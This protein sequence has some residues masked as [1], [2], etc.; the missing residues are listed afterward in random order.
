MFAYVGAVGRVGRPGLSGS[1]ALAK[2]PSLSLD[3]M[4][5]GTLDPRITF[6]RAST[7][8]YTDASG[9]IQTAAVNAPR[10]DYDPVTHALRGV[11]IEEQRTNVMF[12]SVPGVGW[13][14]SAVTLVPNS[15]TAPD[16]TNTFVKSANTATT[17]FHSTQ[18]AQAG[19]AN[20][21]YTC[22]AYIKRGEFRYVQFIFDDLGGGTPATIAT[23]DLQTATVSGGIGIITNVG[24][25]VYRCSITSIPTGASTTGIRL[26]INNNTIPNGGF[27]D[28]SYLGVAGE[29]TYIWGAQVEQGAF[30]TSYIPT[31]SVAVTR[32]ADVATMPTNVSWFSSSAGSL[33]AEFAL[34]NQASAGTQG[35]IAQLDDGTPNNS[36]GLITVTGPPVFHTGSVGGIGIISA[37][38][39][40]AITGNPQRAVSSYGGGVAWRGAMS[41]QLATP[42]GSVGGALPATT[43][44]IG[45]ASAGTRDAWKPNGYIRRVTYWS[46]ALSD[47]E[48][49]QVTT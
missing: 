31:T 12:P 27:Y 38:T 2:R 6:T 34:P 48:M 8:T 26:G 3:F 39:S 32:A 23:F 45:G 42:V 29:G 47:A 4:T 25:G 10:W 18:I 17:G 24:N 22:S 33:F 1:V 15:G 7:A 41:G 13:T 28:N 16:G 19:S 43:L 5:P 11:L 44:A 21:T 35:G 36:V 46:R 9:T 14:L 49:Q 20:V 30:P 40:V 37:S